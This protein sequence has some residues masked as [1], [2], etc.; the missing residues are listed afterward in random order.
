MSARSHEARSALPPL[1]E[2]DVVVC[3]ALQLVNLVSTRVAA[4]Y[5]R[6]DQMFGLCRHCRLI[7]TD[8]KSCKLACIST[9]PGA[10]KGFL[11]KGT[12]CGGTSSEKL[13][14]TQK[15]ARLACA[16]AC[17]GLL[18]RY[19]LSGCAHSS[20][21]KVNIDSHNNRERLTGKWPTLS[22]LEVFS[23]SLV[24]KGKSEQVSAEFGSNEAALQERN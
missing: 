1:S 5:W 21:L 4:R 17:L 7:G 13:A 2:V 20:L 15:K 6:R 24:D 19:L 12:W 18:G 10:P 16:R 3:M 23:C 22:S 11:A 8:P 9:D 14:S